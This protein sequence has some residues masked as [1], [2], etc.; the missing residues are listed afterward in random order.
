[1]G[2]AI[3]LIGLT[4]GAVG[5]GVQYFSA[6]EAAKT[7][8][9]FASLNAQAAQV[10]AQMQAQQATAQASL[11]AQ[12]ARNQQ[13]AGEVQAQALRD[14]AE[15]TTR[16]AQIN[17]GR[18]MEEQ[19]RVRSMMMARQGASGATV[20]QGSQL[21]I[22][23]EQAELSAMQNAE[24]V[25]Q[26]NVARRQ[27]FRQA[28]GAQLGADYSSIQA[29]IEQMQGEARASAYRA[30]GVQAQIRGLAG[31]DAARGASMASLGSAAG[32]FGSLAF[33][34]YDLNRLGAFR[35]S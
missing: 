35:F 29:G 30:Q 20:G 26:T 4:L 15:Q 23:I 3:P 1:M 11:S 7:Q 2:P 13:R 6:Q 9:Q 21:D 10:Q 28:E 24:A 14:E 16:V 18:Q 19:A 33:R 27:L 22:L 12:Q 8:S 34:A 25:Y 31:V 32:N 5:A 17:I